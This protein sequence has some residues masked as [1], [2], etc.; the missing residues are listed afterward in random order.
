MLAHVPQR[1]GQQQLS[2]MCVAHV[3]ILTEN[4]CRNP[5]LCMAPEICAILCKKY[6]PAM[7]ESLCSLSFGSRGRIDTIA[8]PERR[9]LV[10]RQNDS[11]GTGQGA[12]NKAAIHP[13]FFP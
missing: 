2:D 5:A 12:G 8:L 9:T 4:T 6:V 10:C 13:L 7:A 1:S 3:D 11:L